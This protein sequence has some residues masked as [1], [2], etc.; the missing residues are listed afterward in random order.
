MRLALDV[1]TRMRLP[2]PRVLPLTIAVT[3]ALLSLKMVWLEQQAL[4]SDPVEAHASRSIPVRPDAS[5]PSSPV[6]PDDHVSGAA[7]EGMTT[8]DTLLQAVRSE[9]RDL[10]RQAASL[11]VR[12]A[13]MQAASVALD[14]RIATLRG[15]QVNIDASRVARDS[16]EEE[17]WSGLVKVYEAMRPAEAATIFDA[18][19]MHTLLA[20][21]DRMNE[22]KAAL[23]LAAMQPER[24]RISTQLLAQ[25]RL[26]AV[27]VAS[28][29][30][31]QTASVP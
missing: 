29:S 6:V 31:L 8:D 4:A 3:V 17:A 21:L 28:R 30:P 16:K 5:A 22:R 2:N 26:S 27:G 10:D 18:L 14:K 23:V 9:K 20:L 12:E 13:A 15:L 25:L 7:A 24:A 11:A 1:D 19:E